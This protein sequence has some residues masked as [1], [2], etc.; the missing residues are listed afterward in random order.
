MDNANKL[1]LRIPS[2]IADTSNEQVAEWLILEKEVGENTPM[3]D[4]LTELAFSYT[5]FRKV[6]YDP[7]TGQ[8]GEQIFI[9]LNSKIMEPADVTRIKV[10]NGDS[11]IFMPIYAG[12]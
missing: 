1:T 12:G 2:S 10:K 11:L 3:A 4:L 7:D 9:V 8:I 5:D 6:V